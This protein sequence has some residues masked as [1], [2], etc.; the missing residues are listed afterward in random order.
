MLSLDHV[1]KMY[2]SHV[3]VKDL[4]FSAKEGS[5][6][7][8]LGS[9]GSG[10]TTTFRMLLGLI[11]KTQG[12]ITYEGKALDHHNQRLFGYLPEERSMLRD[13]KVKDQII[14][15][16]KLK[17]MSMSEINES[18]DYWL[19]YLK[20]EQYRNRRIIELSKGNQ[21]KTQLICALIHDP[22]IYI[23]D[24]PLNGLDIDNVDLFKELCLKL[25]KDGK[26]IL[27]SSHQYNNIEELCDSVV[28]LYQGDCLFKGQLNHLKQ[29][30]E[31]RYLTIY[32]ASV[33]DWEDE[34]G[35]L[36]IKGDQHKLV[37]QT[38]HAESAN[39]LIKRCLKLGINQFKCEM[40]S[41]QML[42]KEALDE[43]IS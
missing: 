17:K 20:I 14:Y 32:N 28:Y 3:G 1:S 25:K 8:I 40:V 11:E 10:K 24:E 31:V 4:S 35:V 30:K 15:L 26:I 41:L 18:L 5:I 7:G 38:D 33:Y 12:T 34:T 22:K 2:G 36:S 42:I 43:R 6:V 27:I 19:K 9:N 23:F 13:L 16:A 21:Q 39:R 37:I 29:K